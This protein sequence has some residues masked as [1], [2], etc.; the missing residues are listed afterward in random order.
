MSPP[1]TPQSSISAFP[2][3]QTP[4]SSKAED[5]PH[6]PA[7]S[8]SS[9]PGT[10]ASAGVS[11]E[12]LVPPPPETTSS[13]KLIVP[14]SAVGTNVKDASVPPPAGIELPDILKPITTPLSPKLV[15][16]NPEDAP[17]KVTPS[18]LNWNP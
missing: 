4:Q 16:S 18:I 10:E 2:P 9:Q 7:Q 17:V 14:P 8:A 12:I 3:L 5:P 1:H 15:I 13:L 6:C 11:A